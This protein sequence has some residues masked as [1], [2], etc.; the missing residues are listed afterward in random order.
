MPRKKHWRLAACAAAAALLPLSVALAA[1]EH[2]AAAG[3]AASTQ[4]IVPPTVWAIL[5]FIVVLAILWKKAFPPILGAMDRRAAEI[6]DALAAAEKANAEAQALIAKH[7]ADLETA[8]Q[9]AAAIIEEGKA[10]AV[11]VKDS[12]LASAK[13]EQ[14]EVKERALRDIERVKNQALEDIQKRAVDLA[15]GLAGDLIKRELSPQEHQDLIQER[16]RGLKPAKV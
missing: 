9:E 15:V 7:H 1:E 3:H 16:V 12:I 4:P 5:S 14:E 13:K 2:G 8:R 11:R 10:D 6:K